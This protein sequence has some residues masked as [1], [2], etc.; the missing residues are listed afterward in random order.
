MLRGEVTGL[1]AR[2]DSDIPSCT[3]APLTS[4][5]R[6]CRPCF[7]WRAAVSGRRTRPGNFSQRLR[8]D[9]GVSP[10]PPVAPAGTGLC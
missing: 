4:G 10:P 8:V 3:T 9:P 7:E 2:H 6:C 5:S 1:R